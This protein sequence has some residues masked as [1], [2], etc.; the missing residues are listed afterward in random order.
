MKYCSLFALSLFC[1]SCGGLE[2]VP[3]LATETP[4]PAVTAQY[5]YTAI[6]SVAARPT[7]VQ[8]EP[9]VTAT[10][11]ELRI[12]A[13]D[14]DTAKEKAKKYCADM[15]PDNNSWQLSCLKSDLKSIDNL[16]DMIRLQGTDMVFISS[17]NHCTDMW[18]DYSWIESCVKNELKSSEELSKI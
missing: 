4:E 1:V 12:S 18:E 9:L 2:L 15:F 11:E 10:P 8:S 3:L 16:N 14:Y 5:T 17:Y 7:E 13:I 6:P